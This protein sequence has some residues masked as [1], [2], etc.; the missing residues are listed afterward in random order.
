MMG[1]FGGMGFGGILWIVLIG[2]V[3]WAVVKSSTR[4]STASTDSARAV[5]D[6]RL[7]RGELSIE[8]YRKLRE[9]LG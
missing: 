1:G 6:T 4:T 9:V 3:I 5:L 2:V 8:E 7:A